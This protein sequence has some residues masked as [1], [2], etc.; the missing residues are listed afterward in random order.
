MMYAADFRCRAREVLQGNWGVAVGTGFVASV[1][2]AV[3]GVVSSVTGAVGT[4][5]AV[6]PENGSGALIAYPMPTLAVSSAAASKN[7]TIFRFII[8]LL[9]I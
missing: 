7:K 4:V 5:A 8:F 6:L 3:S 9:F 1:G 2:D